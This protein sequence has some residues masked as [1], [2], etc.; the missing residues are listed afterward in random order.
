MLKLSD[1]LCF[2]LT[3]GFTQIFDRTLA[4]FVITQQKS[5]ALW[6]PTRGDTLVNGHTRANF[7]SRLSQ[8]CNA[9][10][11]TLAKSIRLKGWTL[12]LVLCATIVWKHHGNGRNISKCTWAVSLLT[13]VLYARTRQRRK[14][15]WQCIWRWNT[16]QGIRRGPGSVNFACANSRGRL[17]LRGI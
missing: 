1:T 11:N 17:P 7:A 8:R 6:S 12:T 5:R 2:R 10:K 9:W 3:T 15:I 14:I 4:N 16:Y 13:H